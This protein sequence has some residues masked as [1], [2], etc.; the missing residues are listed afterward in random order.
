MRLASRVR[1][2]RARALGAHAAAWILSDDATE[3]FSFVALCEYL[4]VDP[5]WLRAGLRRSGLLTVRAFVNH[6]PMR[7]LGRSAA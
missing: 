3:A 5:A 1:T 7:R 4:D 2:V 6:R